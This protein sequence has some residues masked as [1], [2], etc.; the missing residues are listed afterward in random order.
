MKNPH[1]KSWIT[2][3]DIRSLHEAAMA[4]MDLDTADDCDAALEG[5]SLAQDRVDRIIFRNRRNADAIAK[6]LHDMID[7]RDR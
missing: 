2:N 5:D 4:E 7:G 6:T 3:D 1:R